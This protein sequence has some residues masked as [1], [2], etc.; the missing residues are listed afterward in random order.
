M[1]SVPAPH[2]SKLNAAL[3]IAGIR[4]S[5]LPKYPGPN[6]EQKGTKNKAA[7]EEHGFRGMINRRW[8]D[9]RPRPSRCQQ[10]ARPHSS[11]RRAKLG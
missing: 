4:I 5:C 11:G 7:L 6:R 10:K 9:G 2:E 1:S 3:T 8:T